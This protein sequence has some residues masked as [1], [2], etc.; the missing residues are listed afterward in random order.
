M[1]YP[2]PIPGNEG[3][4]LLT[5]NMAGSQL[6]LTVYF[7]QNIKEQQ[8][9]L[10]LNNFFGVKVNTFSKRLISVMILIEKTNSFY[11]DFHK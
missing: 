8:N 4:K 3:K 6:G 7:N 10:G 11:N 1:T 9:G 2:K 5:T